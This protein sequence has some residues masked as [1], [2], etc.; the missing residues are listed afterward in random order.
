MADSKDSRER[1]D[2]FEK[3]GGQ[4]MVQGVE[5][6]P[7]PATPPTDPPPS[8]VRYDRVYASHPRL[9]SSGRRSMISTA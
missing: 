2:S 4:Q 3:R 6:L 9:R 5:R 7:R 1:K 8:V